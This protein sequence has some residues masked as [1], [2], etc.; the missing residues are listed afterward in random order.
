[1][2]KSAVTTKLPR[3][4]AWALLSDEGGFVKNVLGEVILYRSRKGAAQDSDHGYPVRVTVSAE[5]DG[6]GRAPRGRKK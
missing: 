4:K 5:C 6:T 3:V 1:M 2:K